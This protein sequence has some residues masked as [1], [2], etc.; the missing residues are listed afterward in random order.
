MTSEPSAGET[1]RASLGRTAE[2]GS[3]R[4]VDRD[5]GDRRINW[6]IWLGAIFASLA[7]FLIYFHRG[8]ILLFGDAVAHINIARRVF[9]SRTP[10]PLQL[11]TVWLPLPHVLMMPFVVS[12]WMWRTGMGASIPSMVAF[13]FS[14]V[15]IFRLVR[16]ALLA[17]PQS[18]SFSSW[19]AWFAAAIY[20]LNPNLL[21][22]QATAMTESLYLALFIWA[23]VYFSEF[24][25][26]VR[27]E[28]DDLGAA[29]RSLR[30][31]G[32]CLLGACLTRYDGWFVAAVIGFS[33]M[34]TG[35]KSS[36]AGLRRQ[37]VMFLILASMGPILWLAYNAIVYRNGL[38]FANGPYSAKAIERRTAVPGFPPHPGARNP[39]MAALYFVKAG[40]SSIAPDNLQ[41]IWIGFSLLG[42]VWIIAR[43]RKALPVLLL[44]L[45][46]PFYMLS[47]AYGGVP[48]FT[49]TWWPFSLYNVRYGVQLLPALAVFLAMAAAFV[50]SRMVTATGQRAMGVIAAAFVIASYAGVWHAGPT[51]F[52][53]AWVNSRTRLQLENQLA[54][55]L[56]QLPPDSSFLMYL[57][58]HVGALQQAGIPL[59]RAIFEGNH[60]TWIQPTDPQ[61]LW[62]QSLADPT[63]HADFV[64]ACEGDPVW[65]AVHDRDLPVV[66]II[67]VPGQRTATIYRAR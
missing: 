38:E 12:S 46:A 45:P 44:W 32:L 6:C 16:G 34:W 52:R 10:G 24:W 15:G 56:K 47:V 62:E 13:A 64:V 21:Y 30:R 48:I 20:G 67:G 65:L 61:G 1:R 26:A 18:R 60:R 49:P 37:V 39:V 23:L 22:L 5:P 17:F 42:S 27:E 33:V 31:C 4:V 36:I 57:G 59:R 58:E 35:W 43:G 63:K 29:T 51:A 54:S 9:D 40:E 2:G 14:V 41:R 25:R 3:P 50:V 28:N 19:T 55:Q 11:G 53:E 7:S 66:V 8:E